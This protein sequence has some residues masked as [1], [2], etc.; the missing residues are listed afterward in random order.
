MSTKTKGK[1]KTRRKS[2]VPYD[3]LWRIPV[4]LWEKIE[5][6]LPPGKPHPLGCHNPPVDP[7]KARNGI[8]FALRTGCQWNAL[9]A[10]GICSSSSAHRWFQEWTQAGVFLKLWKMGL[11]AYDRR[12][13]LGWRW[14]ALDGAMTKAPLGGEK[15]RPQSHRPVQTRG[16]TQSADRG[17]RPSYRLGHR[18]GPSTRQPTG[19][20]DAGEHPD[21]PAQAHPQEATTSVCGQGLLLEILK[22]FRYTA[23]VPPRGVEAQELKRRTRHKVR[24]WV[25]ERTHSW[26]NRFRRMVIRWE[27]KPENY[28]ALLHLV[29]ALITYRAAGLLG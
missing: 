4:A 5:P 2:K 12:K 15:K 21:P 28:F 24:R 25:V 13:K 10:T 19:A 9:N 16:Q 11:L 7:R 17:P 1:S 18:R 26:M 3:D 23:H 27:K 22:E 14:Q 29:C 6:L 8:F 20:G